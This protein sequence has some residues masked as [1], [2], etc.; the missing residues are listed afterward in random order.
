MNRSNKVTLKRSFNVLLILANA[1]ASNK[2]LDDAWVYDLRKNA[3]KEVVISSGAKPR[4]RCSTA[5]FSF[6]NRVLIFGGD[7]GSGGPSNEL[8]SLRGVH[9]GDGGGVEPPQ[10]T[11][12]LL[13][14][15]GGGGGGGSVPAPRRGHS[16][17]PAEVLGGVLF[18]GGLSEQKSLLG[19][20]KQSEYL[21]DGVVLQRQRETL[22]WRQVEMM[23]QQSK[24][25][26]GNGGGGGGGDG[27]DGDVPLPREKHTVCAL[28]DGRFF[29]FGGE[30]V[31]F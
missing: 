22:V 15:E 12:L 28:K 19:I 4:A 6:S 31:F 7:T 29:L 23:Q 11:Q 25:G 17:A 14:L 18:V 20:K 1:D 13:Q 10:W 24:S 26:G 8:G 5:I 16:V 30:I 9:E 27:E 3:W 2:R 21:M